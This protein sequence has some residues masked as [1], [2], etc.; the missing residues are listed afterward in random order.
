MVLLVPCADDEFHRPLAVCIHSA[1][2]S[3]AVKSKATLLLT[4]IHL[5]PHCNAHLG[6]SL[7]LFGSGQQNA[8]YFDLTVSV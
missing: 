4:Q 6:H 8:D 5:A 2:I 3:S 1:L 7:K